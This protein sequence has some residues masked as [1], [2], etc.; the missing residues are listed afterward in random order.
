MHFLDARTVVFLNILTDALCVAILLMLWRQ[1]RLR[2]KGLGF[3]LLDFLF[4]AIGLLLIAVREGIPLGVS[5]LGSN[6]FVM[7]GAVL[8]YLGLRR[9]LDLP[10]RVRFHGSLLALFMSLQALFLYVVPSL[11][12]RN[13]V[14]STVLLIICGQSTH[15]LLVQVHAGMSRITRGTGI[16]F[17]GFCLFSLFR[18]A[19]ILLSSGPD[20]NFFHSDTGNLIII[21]TYQ[22]L[23]ILLAI[24]MTLMVNRRLLADLH[25]QEGKFSLLFQASPSAVVLSSM[26]NGRILQVNDAFLH[27]SGYSAEELLGRTTVE[28]GLWENTEERQAVVAR[29]ARHEG[30]RG[31]ETHFRRKNGEILVGLFSSEVIELQGEPQ[32]ISVIVDITRRKR[33]EQ[34]RERLVDDLRRALSEVK[35][36]SGLLPICSSC[37]KIR[38]DKGYWSQVE[39]YLRRHTDAEFSHGICPECVRRLYPEYESDKDS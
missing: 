6:L 24:E 5:V 25:V 19:I 30:I 18:I 38:D 17:L 3:W 32:L 36:L 9:F 1:N 28:L 21:I 11:S 13:L 10:V 33:A 27:I 22:L 39:I 8:G 23:L 12:G 15:L 31:E 7:S 29:L 20:Q 2:F 35:T 4:Q 34:E 16:I 37:K 14:V 26:A